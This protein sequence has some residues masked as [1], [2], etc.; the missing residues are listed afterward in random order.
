[1]NSK[2]S[3]FSLS[4]FLQRFSKKDW[5]ESDSDFGPPNVEHIVNFL[6]FNLKRGLQGKLQLKELVMTVDG[7]DLLKLELPNKQEARAL[8][9]RIS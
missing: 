8:R 2:L 9:W 7:Y 6:N 5:A 4:R 3:Q 1:M